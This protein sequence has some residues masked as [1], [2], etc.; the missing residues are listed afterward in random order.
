MAVTVEPVA[1][2]AERFLLDDVAVT[3]DKFDRVVTIPVGIPTYKE[4]H[5]LPAWLKKW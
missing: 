4:L 5:T 1:V 2:V 3:I